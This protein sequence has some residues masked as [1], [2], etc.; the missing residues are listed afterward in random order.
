[1]A[2]KFDITKVIEYFGLDVNSVAEALFPNVRYKK[3]ALDRVLK[4]EAT[5]NAEQLQA[6]ADLA[7]VLTGDL[8][9]IDSWKG[10]TENG[11]LTFIKG[12][13]K[14]KLNYNGVWLSLYKDD[15]LIKQEMF[16]P[17][18][19]LEDFINHITTLIT[20]FNYGNN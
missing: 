9:S 2:Q 6:L 12:D 13:F 5:I 20:N 14:A 10:S 16:T 18:M 15:K 11:C 3:L 7:G 17:N 19:T 4:G 8:F 1:M